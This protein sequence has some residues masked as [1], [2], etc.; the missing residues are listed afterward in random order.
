LIPGPTPSEASAVAAATSS[1]RATSEASLA[2]RRK[3]RLYSRL[4]GLARRATIAHGGAGMRFVQARSYPTE[5]AADTAYEAMTRTIDRLQAH[6]IA[7][8]VTMTEPERTP[9]VVLIH[10]DAELDELITTGHWHG[11]LPLELEP[12]HAEAFLEHGNRREEAADGERL[13]ERTSFEPGSRLTGDGRIVPPD[14]LD[15]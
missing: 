15:D 4:A 13:R 12:S 3:A 6:C 2:I 11:G 8:R 9:L 14:E 7:M 5:A 1:S 10:D